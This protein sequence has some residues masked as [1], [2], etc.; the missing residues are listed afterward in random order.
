MFFRG[1][2]ER[3]CPLQR[4]MTHFSTSMETRVS[5]EA[6][7]IKGLTVQLDCITAWCKIL[8][9]EMNMDVKDGF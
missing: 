9:L 8:Q 1:S 6:I 2:L 7:S 3:K 5:F 4:L